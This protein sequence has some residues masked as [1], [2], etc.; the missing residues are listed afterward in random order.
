MNDQS[1]TMKPRHAL[2]LLALCCGLAACQSQPTR[3]EPA[4]QQWPELRQE[5]SGEGIYRVDPQASQVRI[6]VFRDGAA[7]KLG[8]NHILTVPEFEGYV[9]LPEDLRKAGF[10]LRVPLAKLHIDDPA[11]RAK[12]G[13]GFAG[14]R[15]VSDI[16]G[17]RGNMLGPKGLD[18]EQFPQMRLR[19]L[20]TDGDWPVLAVELEVTLHGV[21]QKQHVMLHIEKTDG[22][23]KA[24]GEFAL[25]QSDYGIT[26]FSALGGLMK[27]ADGVTVAF[28]IVAKPD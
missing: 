12:T 5:F 23:L 4:P 16:E 21:V 13:G 28:E 14:E 3:G 17:T 2:A 19:S 8:H 11:L 22:V 24:R 20:R 26:P 18:A 9:R 1:L 15:S 10:E 27:V 6:Y 25:R 7:A